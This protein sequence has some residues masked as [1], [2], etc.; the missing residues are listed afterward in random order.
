MGNTASTPDERGGGGG[1]GGA[2]NGSRP[3]K[4]PNP[5][6][7]PPPPSSHLAGHMRL[8]SL[9]VGESFPTDLLDSTATTTYEDYVPRPSPSSKPSPL[10]GFA[11]TPPTPKRISIDPAALANY[12][13]PPIG[14]YGPRSPTT[15][16]RASTTRVS[17]SSSAS[18]GLEDERRLKRSSTTHSKVYSIDM[19]DLENYIPPPIGP[20]RSPRDSV[21]STRGQSSTNFSEPPTTP[22][23]PTLPTHPTH[24]PPK[25]AKVVSIDLK[26]LEN[27]VA[28]PIGP[29]RSPRE[30]GE[31][32]RRTSINTVLFDPPGGRL[33]SPLAVRS[34]AFAP[35]ARGEPVIDTNHPRA[36]QY[37]A[38]TF[39]PV[40]YSPSSSDDTGSEIPATPTSSI[41]TVSS[42]F[43]KDTTLIPVS[44]D[45]Q[46]ELERSS[47]EIAK[48]PESVF[49]PSSPTGS[50]TVAPTSPLMETVFEKD[51]ILLAPVHSGA[52][53]F[54]ISAV[55]ESSSLSIALKE[56]TPLVSSVLEKTNVLPPVL[57]VAPAPAKDF[58]EPA[59][60]SQLSHAESTMVTSV[61]TVV[62]EITPAADVDTV[63][64]VETVVQ[65][66]T[67]AAVDIDMVTDVETVVQEMTSAADLD[68][69]PVAPEMNENVSASTL[70][71]ASVIEPMPTEQPIAIAP[72]PKTQF[73]SLAVA[74]ASADTSVPNES[75]TVPLLSRPS[76]TVEL[77][78]TT[79]EVDAGLIASLGFDDSQA[80]EIEAGE[81]FEIAQEPAG[82]VEKD[83]I[84]LDRKSVST[85]ETVGLL[86]E[87]PASPEVPVTLA[88]IASVA[89][90]E[91]ITLVDIGVVKSET[92]EVPAPMAESTDVVFN[93]AV[94]ETP[95]LVVEKGL[96]VSEEVA[97]ELKP[98]YNV[99]VEDGIEQVAPVVS[100]EI[101]E[102]SVAEEDVQVPKEVP[103][104]V[105]SACA[106]L[107]EDVVAEIGFHDS[108]D[109][110]DSLAVEKNLENSEEA[111]AV[112]QSKIVT[113]IVDLMEKSTPS[114]APADAFVA[115][116]SPVV[117]PVSCGEVTTESSAIV[118]EV[119][120][121]ITEDGAADI[122]SKPENEPAPVIVVES[123]SDDSPV[124]EPAVALVSEPAV[125]LVS[126][127]TIA[128][129]P[130]PA[131]SPVSEP[132]VASVLEPAVALALEP[133]V[134]S[135]LEP[136]VVPVPEPAVTLVSEP[137]V[138]PAPEPAVVPVSEP[139]VVPV[140]EPVVTPVPEPVT[141]PLVEPIVAPV[142]EPAVLPVVVPLVD[143]QT[144]TTPSPPKRKV[145]HRIL[146]KVDPASLAILQDM[147]KNKKLEK[148]VNSI[149]RTLWPAFYLH[150]LASLDA[151]S[152]AVALLPPS[153]SPFDAVTVRPKRSKRKQH[154]RNKS[155][156]QL[157]SIPPPPSSPKSSV[158]ASAVSTPPLESDTGASTPPSSPT[159]SS[160]P[161]KLVINISVHENE[162]PVSPLQTP[163]TP[164][165]GGL[166]PDCLT[167]DDL[168]NT[169]KYPTLAFLI[170]A[171]AAALSANAT[172]PSTAFGR[173]LTRVRTQ[174]YTK[175]LKEKYLG[176]EW[177]RLAL[178]LGIGEG[179]QSTGRTKVIAEWYEWRFERL[180]IKVEEMEE[181]VNRLRELRIQAD[182]EEEQKRKEEEALGLISYGRQEP[183]ARIV[184]T[185]G[186]VVPPKR[187]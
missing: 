70:P 35:S 33:R 122:L 132:A 12:V 31:S 120:D 13:P 26:D 47:S 90:V 119:A 185:L 58:V 40:S 142:S 172:Y 111:P 165:A 139:V 103:V 87:S 173:A 175:R 164:P 39:T 131:V 134:A 107:A 97:L 34:S 3:S 41:S 182:L 128:P 166:T 6:P 77:T 127:P 74:A 14:P 56:Q 54:E 45:S 95:A 146:L 137:V 92:N 141:A 18:A 63:T 75:T 53:Q 60:E 81:A 148:Q 32:P 106:I 104:V 171:A 112:A 20:Y 80:V 102:S 79:M 88:T 19:K 116:I 154:D 101:N 100:V 151:K 181:R 28:P 73:E 7:K 177:I 170:P 37:S 113:T 66:M 46:G 23:S 91:P 126:E 99:F 84:L 117:E 43:S 62:Q 59:E 52:Q 2:H 125:A 174:L 22:R 130:E 15:L 68:S 11:T 153:S 178:H 17:T 21:E 85:E 157:P 115:K 49:W 169:E 187:V 9:D 44:V 135:V 8:P 76:S 10:D 168:G 138:V 184:F 86:Q 57:A 67:F 98:T 61:E 109:I 65:E 155:N 110:D 161:H 124:P 145:A 159:H 152:R 180:K 71:T 156:L 114:E 186:R 82:A 16:S 149:P 30:S 27:Y 29:Y 36:R 38:P 69:V 179:G 89:I 150:L 147:M 133:A 42:S 55:V 129:V 123:S 160:Q 25:R 176:R 136:V 94:E 167:P 121:I 5:L 64:D 24:E 163:T 78:I 50:G 143:E 48:T 83:V 162:L 96:Q 4:D 93:N 51:E 72:A 144:W 140:P 118:S 158:T 108:V 183:K 105:E 1:G